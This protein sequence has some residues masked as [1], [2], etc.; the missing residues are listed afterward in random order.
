MHLASQEGLYSMNFICYLV[1]VKSTDS[2]CVGL[3]VRRLNVYSGKAV[4]KSVHGALS[5]RSACFCCSATLAIITPFYSASLVETVQSDIASEKPGFFDV[6]RE[7]MCRLV[8]WSSPQKGTSG[9]LYSCNVLR[10]LDSRFLILGTVKERKKYIFLNT[11]HTF[12]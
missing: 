9:S 10:D 11:L 1:Y 3:A 2:S 5:S 4:Y 7:G 8:S 12:L 6:F